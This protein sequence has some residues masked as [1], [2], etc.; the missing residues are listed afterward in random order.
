MYKI[1]GWRVLVQYKESFRLTDMRTMSEQIEVAAY[2]A[3]VLLTHYGHGKYVLMTLSQ[4]EKLTR[5]GK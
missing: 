5:K 4:Y 1:N 2:K 3:P